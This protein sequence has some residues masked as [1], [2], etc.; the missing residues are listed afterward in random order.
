MNYSW[1]WCFKHC[2]F[3]TDLI[4]PHTVVL[5]FVQQSAA[6][7]KMCI[8]F[9]NC[10]LHWYEY[11]TLN[12]TYVYYF[13]LISLKW[14]Y[15][16]MTCIEVFPVLFVIWYICIWVLEKAHSGSVTLKVTWL[17][18]NTAA[19]CLYNCMHSDWSL[20][21]GSLYLVN[22]QPAFELCLRKVEGPKRCINKKISW[23]SKWQCAGLSSSRC[24]RTH[25]TLHHG[26]SFFFSS[27][28]EATVFDD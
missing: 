6:N 23:F 16:G 19:T 5:L 21:P 15:F 8:L 26:I 25:N 17:N 20:W 4:S 11:R 12:W 18:C 14:I 27:V 3:H 13:L 9:L 22:C 24:S 10:P 1:V 2:S 28:F 7:Q